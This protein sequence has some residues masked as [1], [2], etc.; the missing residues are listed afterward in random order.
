V[1]QL[2]GRRSGCR[3]CRPGTRRAEHVAELIS[4]RASAPMVQYLQPADGV[5]T[6]TARRASRR[7]SSPSF[8]RCS[9][10]SRGLADRGAATDCAP[11]LAGPARNQFDVVYPAFH[12]MLDFRGV[13]PITPGGPGVWAVTMDDYALGARQ[14]H[15]R[16]DAG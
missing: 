10:P 8:E 14:H 4:Y 3:N 12:R 9:P 6:V 11:Q 16:G 7:A 15:H 2:D 5:R 1:D 13:S